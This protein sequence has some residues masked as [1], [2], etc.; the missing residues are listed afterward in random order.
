MSIRLNSNTGG[1]G[2][3]KRGLLQRADER[4]DLVDRAAYDAQGAAANKDGDTHGDHTSGLDGV[5]VPQREEDDSAATPP[6]DAERSA[7]LAVGDSPGG[8]PRPDD[9][10][11]Y[12]ES[13]SS[14]GGAANSHG[15]GTTPSVESQ[16]QRRWTTVQ[17]WPVCPINSTRVDREVLGWVDHGDTVCRTGGFRFT[18]DECDFSHAVGEYLA[19]GR[20]H[21]IKLKGP[22]GRSHTRA[23]DVGFAMAADVLVSSAP[24]APRMDPLSAE[25]VDADAESTNSPPQATAAA[26]QKHVAPRRLANKLAAS[27][28][29]Y[30]RVCMLRSERR[31]AWKNPDARC[32]RFPYSGIDLDRV[33]PGTSGFDTLML[34]LCRWPRAWPVCALNLGARVLAGAPDPATFHGRFANLT[35]ISADFAARMCTANATAG[36]NEESG[37]LRRLQRNW[38][39]LQKAARGRPA[40]N[41]APLRC[42]DGVTEAFLNHCEFG[43]LV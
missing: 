28:K 25:A 5:G 16:W 23:S 1:T 43:G 24:S 13:D 41:A 19:S 42:N 15:D 9:R 10:R 14:N 21:Y 22:R 7:S 29:L 36:D 30:G 8:P 32:V 34:Q 33:A 3:T 37:E 27:V 39:A 17:G 6:D 26:G 38:R 40:P 12:R 11:D 31:S 35:G 18:V 20:P 2:A 4:D